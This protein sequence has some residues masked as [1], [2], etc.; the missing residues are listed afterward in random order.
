MDCMT[1]KKQRQVD[2]FLGWWGW[3]C[4]KRAWSVFRGAVGPE[5]SWKRGKIQ[6][7]CSWDNSIQC[8]YPANLNVHS[9]FHTIAT[10]E[11]P[12]DAFGAD[13]AWITRYTGDIET[14]YSRHSTVV[15]IW[16]GFRTFTICSGKSTVQASGLA[17]SYHDLWCFHHA[18]QHKMTI[19]APTII[20]MSQSY[21]CLLSY[22]HT[23]PGEGSLCYM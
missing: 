13:H 18:E 14:L 4:G 15:A 11:F 19:S 22:K 5:K 7:M 3:K 10:L 16:G 20:P 2:R 21:S 6:N 23:C 9:L 8:N 1:W 12:W 17:T